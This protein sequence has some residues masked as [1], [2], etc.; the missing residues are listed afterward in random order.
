KIPS[1]Q[2]VKGLNGLKDNIEL[3]ATGGA[4]VNASGNTITINAG[5]GSTG[6]PIT[7][8]Q[9]TNNTLDITGANGPTVTIGVKNGGITGTYLADNAVS[10]AKVVDAG[11][12]TPDLADNVV[13][14]AKIADGAIASADLADNS[15]TSAKIANATVV[16][17]DLAD[18]AV[19]SAKIIDASIVASDLADSVVNSLKIADA[20]VAT[21][22]LADGAVTSAKVGF[23]L[24]RTYYGT[25]EYEMHYG[26]GYSWNTGGIRFNSAGLYAKY[27]RG[28]GLILGTGYA[29]YVDGNAVITGGDLTVSSTSVNWTA[30]KPATVKV[31]DGSTVRLFS[32][33]AAEVYFTDY[34][35]SRL[36]GGKAHVELD[37]RF[38]ETVTVDALHPMK[39]FVQLEGDCRGVFVANKSTTSFDV[40]ELQQGTSDAPFTYRVVC[41]RRYYEDE[42][43]ATPE[44]D[45]SFNERMLKEAWPEMSGNTN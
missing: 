35:T 8:I 12:T 11:I 17:A 21:V 16:T 5:A 33:E 45:K 6:G 15:V 30:T 18:N 22:D 32:E 38:L 20:S 29:L 4:T 41:K 39:V 7:G 26:L 10:S 14:S 23:P 42:R 19:T 3:V 40:V 36:V 24:E 28:S 43:L 34:G 9:N 25:N 27:R 37:A 13:T 31:N 1:A 2:V 44:Q